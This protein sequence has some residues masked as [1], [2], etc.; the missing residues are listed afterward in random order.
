MTLDLTS[1]PTHAR[2]WQHNMMAFESVVPYDNYSRLPGHLIPRGSHHLEPLVSA[3]E[4]AE[5]AR[6]PLRPAE[7]L[8]QLRVGERE[9]QHVPR[10]RH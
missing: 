8:E 9:R 3:L 5:I 6:V 2:Q 1:T 7:H 10:R 4:E